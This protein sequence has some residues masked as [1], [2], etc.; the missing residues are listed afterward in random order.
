MAATT[1]PSIDDVDYLSRYFSQSQESHLS[2]I[3]APILDLEN[4]SVE[5]FGCCD[6]VDAILGHVGVSLLFVSFHFRRSTR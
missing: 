2:V 5:Y 3:A 1:A 4:R 6:E